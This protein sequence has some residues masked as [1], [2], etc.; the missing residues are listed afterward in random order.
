MKRIALLGSTGSIGTQTLEVARWRGY[1]VESLA[2]GSNW[3]LL[4][5]QA[6]EFRPRIVSCAPEVVEALRPHLPPGMELLSGPEGAVRAATVNADSV[7]AAI[8]GIAG[9]APTAAALRAGRHVA[10]ANK[11]SLVVAGPLMLELARASGARI[12]PV[13][14][15]HAALH[16]CLTS[17]PTSSVAGLVLTASGGPFLREPA[18]LSAVTPEEA[19]KHPNWVMGAKVT[20]DS[21]TLF[22]KGLEVLEA[23]FL[24][25]VPLE[26]I[27]VVIHPQSLVHGMV[28]FQDGNIL[29]QVGP[30]DMRIPIQY[31]LETPARSPVPLAPLPLAGSWEFLEPDLER[32]PA[33]ELAYRAGELGGLAPAYLN[34]ADEVAVEAFLAGE[35]PFTAIAEVLAEVLNA[36]PTEALTWNAIGPANEHARAVAREAAGR[37]SN[38]PA[39]SLSGAATK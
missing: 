31:A 39:G 28:R 33:L 5:E 15:E 14:S 29:A 30:H 12:T 8:P 22:N 10:L 37:F 26:K 35:I 32:F 11:E 17:Q 20:I 19:L 21:A 16:Q 3:E 25:G 27:E 38:A 24:F 34:A 18:D 6:L 23:H 9:L 4:L 2:A 36:A 1:R 13:D 7:I